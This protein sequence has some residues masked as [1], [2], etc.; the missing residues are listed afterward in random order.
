MS[1]TVDIDRLGHQG[2]GIAAGPVFVP[3]TL[4][5]ERVSG[6]PDG[7]ALRDVR[8]ERPSPDRVRAP[9]PHYDACG[10]CQLQHA[11]DDFVAGWKLDVVRSA[12][13]AQGLDAPFGPIATSPPASRRRATLAVRRTRKGALA[14]FHGRASGTI[15]AIP[16]CRL[17]SPRLMAGLPAAEALALAGASRKGVLDVALTDAVAGLDVA[18]TGGKPLDG[19]L[20]VQLAAL[21]ETHDLARLAWDDEVV[22]TRRPPVQRMGNAEVVPPPGAF[23]QATAHGEAALLAAVRDALGDAA[24]VVDLFAGCGTFTLPL[25]ETAQV[26][27]VEGSAAMLGALELGW[28]KAPGLKAVTTRPRDLFRNP[29]TA[30][31]FAGIDAVVI[32]PPRAGA[33]AQVA[34]LASAQVP[35]IAYVSC[36]PVTFARDAARLV[37]AGYRIDRVQVVDQF[38]WSAHCELAASLSLAH[39]AAAD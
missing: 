39:M 3:R 9:C 4:P 8:I 26:H 35:R 32:D 18:V 1:V 5:G 12:L 21:A 27:A 34:E 22:V 16:D 2:D 25:A 31:E 13:A 7:K 29:L 38:R 36:N 6:D 37:A 11:S 17:L 15:T 14:G 28:R 24:R 10:G 33:E 19:P 20:R 30:G 23:L